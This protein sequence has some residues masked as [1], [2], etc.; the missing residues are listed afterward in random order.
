VGR[1]IGAVNRV[2]HGSFLTPSCPGQTHK[3]APAEYVGQA[4]L[5]YATRALK[6]PS[7]DWLPQRRLIRK[8]WQYSCGLTAPHQTQ[9]TGFYGPHFGAQ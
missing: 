9:I 2:V 6:F 3:A 8:G 4:A 7:A 5:V 1:A